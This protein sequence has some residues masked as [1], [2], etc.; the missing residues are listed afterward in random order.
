MQALTIP[1]LSVTASFSAHAL[2]LA[3][4]PLQPITNDVVVQTE[5][6]V[7]GKR[8]FNDTRLSIDNSTSCA[9][10]HDLSGGGADNNPLSTG[11]H[12]TLGTRNSP[13]VF[14][15]VFNFRQLWD[16]R[17]RTLA[18]QADMALDSEMVM[19]FDWEK[20]ARVITE[21]DRYK[22]AFDTL[23]GGFS[24][25]HVTD[26]IAEFEKTLVTVN[27]PFDQY[28]KGNDKA[29]TPQQKRGYELFKSYGCSS[30]HQ[31]KNVGGNMFQ[32]FGVL[33]DINLRE[34]DT[35]SD[36]LGRYQVTGNEWDKYVFKVPSL[37][38]V[39]LTPP[40]FHDG[41]VETLEGAVDVMI[42]FQ[43]G[44]TVPRQDREDIVSFLHSLAGEYHDE[45]P[46]PEGE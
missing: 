17:A 3:D 4:E 29:I 32:K 30:C 43:L 35:G 2:N 34:N 23:Y 33:K 19:K 38:M 31:G 15:S 1:L 18:E 45:L 25:S 46:A 12:G 10:C 16:G 8:L 44:R 24:R 27:A 28:L 36:D 22:Q 13:T 42:E 37:R 14:N 7:L 39:S 26:A 40:Y 6:A 9:S 5:K 11:A 41:S 21:D 20:I